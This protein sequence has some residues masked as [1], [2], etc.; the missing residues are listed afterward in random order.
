MTLKEDLVILAFIG[1]VAAGAV[2]MLFWRDRWR[3]LRLL[4]IPIL[5]ALWLLWDISAKLIPGLPRIP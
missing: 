5:L 4:S 3:L 1:P 2:W